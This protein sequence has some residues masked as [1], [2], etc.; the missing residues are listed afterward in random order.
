MGLAAVRCVSRPAKLGKEAMT[1]VEMVSQHFGDLV[2]SPVAAKY[3]LSLRG[4]WVWWP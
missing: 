1:T 2:L 3:N 4:R